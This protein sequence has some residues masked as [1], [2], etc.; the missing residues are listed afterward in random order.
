MKTS[1]QLLI[2]LLI[3]LFV[4]ITA[5]AMILK[6][7]Y[8]KIDKDDPFY[9]Y[10]T[11]TL[12]DFSAVRMEGKFFGLILI[13][14]GDQFEIKTRTQMINAEISEKASRLKWKVRNDT[15]VLSYAA[16]DF[17]RWFNARSTLNNPRSNFYIFAPQLTSVQS[18]SFTCKLSGWDLADLE[19]VQQG[20]N[21]AMALTESRI[22]NLS[23][24]VTQGGLMR[25]EQPNQIAKAQVEVRDVSTFTV[26][27][28]AI[29]S[30]ALKVDPEAQVTVP[31]KLFTRLS[32]S[33]EED[34]D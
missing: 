23:A 15:L 10:S 2:G 21:S 6:S 1:N 14:P 30:L 16:D 34:S 28:S 27:P 25:I 3:L 22:G 17:P 7:E 4:G 29:D 8:E 20:E 24:S 12:A 33:L 11:D 19:L 31:G 9:G 32:E 13:Q 5:S 26:R 18:Q